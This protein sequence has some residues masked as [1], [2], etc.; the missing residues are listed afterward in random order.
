[1]LVCRGPSGLMPA[2]NGTTVKDGIIHAAR[3]LT[4]IN[5]KTAETD[6]LRYRHLLAVP[7]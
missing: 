2:S 5:G 1:M 6:V 7:I 4:L 3:S